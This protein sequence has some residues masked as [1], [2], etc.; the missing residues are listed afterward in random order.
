MID[1]VGATRQSL[2]WVASDMGI[3]PQYPIWDLEFFP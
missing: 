3:D 2:G 1:S